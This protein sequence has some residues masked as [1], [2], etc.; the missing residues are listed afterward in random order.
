[1]FDRYRSYFFILKCNLKL[2]ALKCEDTLYIH[3]KDDCAWIRS[4]VT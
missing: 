2:N 4:N 3:L 1:M